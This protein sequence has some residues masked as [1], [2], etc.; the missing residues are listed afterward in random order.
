MFYI[1]VILKVTTTRGV[2]LGGSGGLRGAQ[3]S[4]VPLVNAEKCQ[5]STFAIVF[6]AF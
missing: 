3:G 4:S 1:N 5:I 6:A 2:E